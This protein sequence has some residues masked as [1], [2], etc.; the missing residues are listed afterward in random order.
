MT[1]SNLL[2]PAH[3][4][5]ALL[6]ALALLALGVGVTPGHAVAA[7]GAPGTSGADTITT[8]LYPGWNMVGWVEPSTPTS[9]LFDAIPALR[10]VSAWDAEVQAYQHAVLDDAAT[11]TCR[12]SRPAP[13]CGCASMA[14]RPSSGD[15]WCPT[16]LCCFFSTRGAT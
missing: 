7:S 6:A 9:E 12:R 10:Q 16:C 13:G 11:T 8:V 1:T 4:R 15:A 2:T 3:L 14:P 5:R